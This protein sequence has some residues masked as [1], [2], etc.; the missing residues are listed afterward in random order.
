M[1]EIKVAQARA[2]SAEKMIELLKNS[3]Q[4]ELNNAYQSGFANGVKSVVG[5]NEAS[6]GTSKEKEE[7]KLVLKNN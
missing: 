1:K 6:G 7:T 2:E 5:N 4:K 3:F